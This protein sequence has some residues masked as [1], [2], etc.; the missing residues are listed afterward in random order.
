MTHDPLAKW[1]PAE[2][3]PAITGAA[4]AFLSVAGAKVILHSPMWCAAITEM[5]LEAV[6][7]PC[8]GLFSSFVEEDDLFFGGEEALREALLEAQVVRGDALL[9]VAVNCAPALIGDDVRGVCAAFA[10]G[11]PVAV[12]EAGGFTGEFDDGYEK[13]FLAVLEALLPEPCPSTPGT[14]NLIGFSPV[15]DNAIETLRKLKRLLSFGKIKTNLILG[16]PET[17]PESI[18]QAGRAQLNVILHEARGGEIARFLKARL[19]QPFITAPIPYGSKE[20]HEWIATIASYFR[21]PLLLALE[22]EIDRL[23]ADTPHC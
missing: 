15:D 18:R 9:G 2:A 20:T 23:K 12:A 13:A 16:E 8:E 19:G 6:G 14:V 7:M 17:S 4:A 10:D 21:L 1:R 22:K 11:V 3:L 5:R